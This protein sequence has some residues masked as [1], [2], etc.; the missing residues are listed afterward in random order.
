MM[1][2]ALKLLIGARR[3]SAGIAKPL[4]RY[5]LTPLNSDIKASSTGKGDEPEKIIFPAVVWAAEGCSGNSSEFA[6]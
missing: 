2:V 1:E 5:A 3:E 6:Q 4:E